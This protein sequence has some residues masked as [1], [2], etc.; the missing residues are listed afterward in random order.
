MEKVRNDDLNLNLTW[1]YL[2]TIRWQLSKHNPHTADILTEAHV[3]CTDSKQPPNVP[4]THAHCSFTF[5]QLQ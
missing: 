1:A 3:F 5:R 2:Q 4:P